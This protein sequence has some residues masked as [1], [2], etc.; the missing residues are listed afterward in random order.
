MYIGVEYS[1]GGSQSRGCGVPHHP[2]GHHYSCW[3]VPRRATGALICPAYSK[4]FC[5]CLAEQHALLIWTLSPPVPDMFVGLE[6]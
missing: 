3:H 6:E 2:P 4:L 5:A 1:S